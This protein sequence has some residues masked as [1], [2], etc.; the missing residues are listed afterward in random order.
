MK[1]MTSARARSVL[2]ALFISFLVVQLA[3]VV[4]IHRRMWPEDLQ[5][6]VLKLLAIYSV[7]LGVILGMY[8]AFYKTGATRVAASA[9]AAIALCGIWNVLIAWRTVAFALAAEDSPKELIDYL[10]TVS[11]ASGFLVVGALAFFFAKSK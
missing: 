1:P 4:M 11:S 10:E 7:H 8:F 5:A 9:P 6:I 3:A 2:L